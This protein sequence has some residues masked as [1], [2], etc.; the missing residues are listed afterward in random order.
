[1][2]VH[3]QKIPCGLAAGSIHLVKNRFKVAKKA[4]FQHNNYYI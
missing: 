3:N 4:S 2:G 1:M